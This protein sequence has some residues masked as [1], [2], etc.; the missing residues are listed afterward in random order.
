MGTQDALVAGLA[1]VGRGD[2]GMAGG[3]AA[4]LGE[5]IRGGFAVPDGFVVLTASYRAAIDAAGLA[6]GTAAGG[7]RGAIAAAPVPDNVAA[8]ILDAYRRLGSG[9][10][11][12]RSSATAEDL[13][14]ATFAGQQDSFLNIMGEPEVVDAVRRCWASLWTDRAVAYRNKAGID[15]AQVQIAVV[16]QAMVDADTAGV[17]FTANPVTGVRS[18][19]VVNASAGLG[20]AVVSGL[21]TPDQFVLSRDGRVLSRQAGLREVVI[22]S[23]PDGGTESQRGGT[24]SPPLGE[25]ALLRLAEVCSRIEQHFGGPQDIEWAMAGDRLW[26]V[27]ARPLTAVPPAPVEV[28]PLR[29]LM[30]GIIAELLPVRPYP[31]DMSSWTVHG[32]GRILTRMMAEIPGIELS[33]EDILPESRGVVQEMVPPRP[34]P[35]VHTLT[36][37]FRLVPKIRR[38]RPS[39]W[40]QDA[41]FLAFDSD[42]A[43]LSRLDVSGMAW[44]ELVDV[45][46][47]AMAV[48]DGFITLRIDYLPRVGFELARLKVL[49][50][51]TGLGRE[52]SSLSTVTA[53]RTGDANRALRGLA[54]AVSGNRQWR[55]AVLDNSPGELGDLIATDPAFAPLHQQ[56]DGYLAEFGHRETTSA[57]LVSEPTWVDDPAVLYGA[58]RAMLDQPEPVGQEDRAGV[59]ELRVAGRTRVP[60]RLRAAIASAA[61]GTRSGIA[62]REDS[63][64]HAMRLVPPIRHAMLEAGARL[65]DAGILPSADA[66]FHLRLEE[67]TGIQEPATLTQGR[68][69]DLRALVEDRMRRRALL[70]G[71]PLISPLTLKAGRDKGGSLVSGTPAGGGRATG[72]VRIIRGPGDFSRLLQGEIMVCPYTNP[73]WT[74]LFQIAAG[75]IVD[76][77]GAA[78]HAAIVAREYGLSAIM[79]TGTGTSVLR[80]GQRVTVDGTTGLVSGADLA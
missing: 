2:L 66:V 28:N 39:N 79:G 55:T 12:V 19:I 36:A 67:V 71:A 41:R 69:A 5:L 25:S 16:V 48:L 72:A 58:V 63:H 53:T 8:A 49:L 31:L 1:Q 26:I 47:R 17:A 61:R 62:F 21:V 13:P 3:K 40:M 76:T 20:E 43:E 65:T 73:S 56:I 60:G 44:A 22:R 57:F 29:K 64:F 70:A 32:H 59:A 45:P 80:D 51:L 68:K 9:P 6:T 74:P 7:L 38:F 46:R 54:L 4:N 11:A 78:S 50:G 52:F 30:T 15:H 18:E 35:T 24:E 10:V 37:P 75:V 42:A 34:R 27:Q 33:I 14:G 23:K 77:G